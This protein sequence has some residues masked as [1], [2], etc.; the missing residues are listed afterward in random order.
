MRRQKLEHLVTTGK[1]DGKRSRGR[2]RQKMLDGLATW[3]N[4]DTPI[5]MLDSVLWDR[6]GWKSL[7]ADAIGHGTE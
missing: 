6:G 1:M 7:I 4:K 2:Q 3:M 5:N